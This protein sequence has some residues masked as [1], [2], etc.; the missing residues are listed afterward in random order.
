MHGDVCL[1][2]LGPLF[3]KDMGDQLAL[4]LLMSIFFW[5]RFLYI[6][7]VPGHFILFQFQIFWP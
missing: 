1:F 5:T 6:V 2:L 4:T 7:P 3:E